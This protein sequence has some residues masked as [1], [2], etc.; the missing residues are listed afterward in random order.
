MITEARPST[1][2][3]AW[4]RL[5]AV[6]R[7]LWEENS[8]SAVETQAVVE[9]FKGEVHRVDTF[10]ANAE[11][12]HTLE[13]AEHESDLNAMRGHYELEVSGLKKRLAIQ[14]GA[15][16]EKDARIEELLK[17]LSRKEEENLNFHSEVLRMSASGDEIK[18]KK[19]AEFY[20]ELMSKEAALSESWRQRHVALEQEHENRQK[21]H[22]IRQS[23]LDAWEN[24]R[25]SEEESLQKRTTDVDIKSAHLAQEYRKKQQEVEDLKASLQ[26]SIADLVREYQVRLRGADAAPAPIPV[27]QQSPR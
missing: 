7:R 25:I 15:I 17:T 16:R 14:D 23:E 9:E 18:T 5:E 2:S 21:L 8:H 10:M 27:L 12:R 4:Q 26:R 3:A 1:L 6:C 22:A 19:M 24:R 11:E 13:A 20:Q